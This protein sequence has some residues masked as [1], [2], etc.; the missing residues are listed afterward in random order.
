MS[1]F[2]LF[3]DSGEIMLSGFHSVAVFPNNQSP[4]HHVRGLRCCVKGALSSGGVGSRHTPV[5]ALNRTDINEL[6]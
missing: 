4:C 2:I 5:V 1:D 6:F 3:Y